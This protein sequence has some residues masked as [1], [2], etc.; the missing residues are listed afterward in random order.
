MGPAQFMTQCVTNREG[1]VKEPHVAKVRGVEPASELPG[2]RLGEHGEKSG[3]VF[4]AGSS[5][6]LEFHD[7]PADLPAGLNLNRIDRP[8]RPVACAPNQLAEVME[9]SLSFL[10]AVH[11]LVQ[12]VRHELNL[13]YC[14]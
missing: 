12:I 2:P 5:A 8:E 6:L 13:S 14:L 11:P 4:G 1:L 9:Q 10:R 3:A 7:V